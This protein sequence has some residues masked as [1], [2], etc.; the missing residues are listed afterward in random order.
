MHFIGIAAQFGDLID[1]QA[2]GKEQ[3]IGMGDSGLN[4]VVKK[5]DFKKLLIQILEIGFTYF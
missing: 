1:R 2:G 5:G 4:Q 3:I